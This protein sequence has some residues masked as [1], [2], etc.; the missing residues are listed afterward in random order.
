MVLAAASIIAA[1]GSLT[2]LTGIRSRTKLY[3]LRV[4]D[5]HSFRG[6]SLPAVNGGEGLP[7]RREGAISGIEAP[8]TTLIVA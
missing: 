5:I 3:A 2:M 6:H 8:I 7:C 4:L 1:L